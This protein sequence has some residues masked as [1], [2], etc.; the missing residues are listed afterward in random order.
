MNRVLVIACGNPLRADDS[1]G[2]RI[3][4][5]LRGEGKDAGFLA[6]TVQQLTPELAEEVSHAGTAIFVDAA[7]N[8]RPG[9]VEIKR[10][11]PAAGLWWRF[12]HS[13]T[14]QA[15]LTLG[16]ELYDEAP[17][18]AFLVTIG[19][20]SFELGGELSGAVAAGVREAVE[21][22][23]SIATRQAAGQGSRQL[24]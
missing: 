11:R 9:A 14:P 23:R 7:E 19:A 13:L 6:K 8:G 15:L 1:A 2:W 20:A 17:A 18:E 12:T 10:I 22:V 3:V 21:A 24:W 16:R 4:E 5:A